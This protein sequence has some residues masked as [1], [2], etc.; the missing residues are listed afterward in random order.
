MADGQSTFLAFLEGLYGKEAVDRLMTASGLRPSELKAASDAFAPTFLSSLLSALPA[1]MAAQQANA[2]SGFGLG[3]LWPKEV[4]EAMQGYLAKAPLAEK[5]QSGATGS[6]TSPFFPF[7][8]RDPLKEQ[9]DAMERLQK[10]FMGQVAQMELMEDVSRRTGIAQEQL[11]T[12]FPMLTT[13]GLLPLM[14]FSATP[15]MDDPADWVDYL[16]EMGRRTMRQTTKDL[17]ALP[18]PLHAAFEGL[19]AG[20]YPKPEAPPERLETDHVQAVRDA[21]LELQANY[22]KGLG[23]LFESY[24]G[25]MAQQPHKAGR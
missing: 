6:A 12:L 25:Q 11:Q 20:L 18:N 19:R 14:P 15:A 9:Q 5:S 10:V 8:T 24:A 17:E 16:G 7:L 21:S 3:A 2:T 13:Y 4:A 22:L 1:N 23:S